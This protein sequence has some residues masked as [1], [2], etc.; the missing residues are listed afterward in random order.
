MSEEL[1][2][3][4]KPSAEGFKKGRKLYFIPLIYS[5][6]ESPTEYLEKYN[7]Y[8]NQVENHISDLQLKLGSINKIYHELI[9]VAGEEGSK[10]IGELNDKCY[11]VI[12]A[13][14]DKGAEL[15]AL[16]KAELLTEFMDWSRCLAIGLQNQQVFTKVYESYTEAGKKRNEYIVSQIDETLKEDETGMLL[17]REG[18]Q[19]QFPPDIQVFYVAP[20][21]LDEIKRWFRDREAKSQKDELSDN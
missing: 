18:S 17:M 1:G 9:A 6:A 7:K 8:W 2:K 5:G 21:A 10:V 3:I 14:L 20:P 19:V 13:I 12:K 11:H 15:E 16:E 4:E